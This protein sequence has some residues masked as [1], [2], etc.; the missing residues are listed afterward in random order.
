MSGLN[1]PI[2]L[3]AIDVRDGRVVRLKQGDYAQETVYGDDPQAMAR[4]F[5]DN[6]ARWL[7]LV[8]LDAAREGGYTLEPLLRQI[9]ADECATDR[10]AAARPG[11]TAG[12]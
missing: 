10:P 5:A 3:P 4:C 11:Q 8:D 9:D 12:R 1:A 2:I 6:G 7:H